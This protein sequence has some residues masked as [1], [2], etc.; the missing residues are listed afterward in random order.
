MNSFTSSL[1]Q[2]ARDA[3]RDD[4][5]VLEN[6]AA[7]GAQRVIVFCSASGNDTLSSVEIAHDLENLLDDLRCESHRR[8]VEQDHRRLRHQRPA[9]RRHL[10]LAARRIAGKACAP[11]AQ[12]RKVVIDLVERRC[13]LAARPLAR[14]CA[15]QQVFLDS[16]V[17]EAM[18]APSLADAA[19]HELVRRQPVDTLARYSIVPLVTSPRSAAGWT[20]QRRRSAFAPAARRCRLPARRDTPFSTRIT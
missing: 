13:D 9:D 15:G 16:Q 2:L 14:E 17:R 8:L 12:P 4:A 6:V 10:L 19:A 11:L 3:V 5:A 7:S 20:L 18:A 1:Q